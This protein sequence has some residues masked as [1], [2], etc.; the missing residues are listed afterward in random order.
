MIK[1]RVRDEQSAKELL[2]VLV[3]D[4]VNPSDIVV[5]SSSLDKT[6]KL[7]Y[8]TYSKDSIWTEFKDGYINVRYANHF[9][10][11]CPYYAIIGIMDGCAFSEK[12]IVICISE[13]IS[14]EDL[15]LFNSTY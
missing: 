9:I 6:K 13:G 11:A 15:R 14:D 8:S 4:L 10:W 1:F 7:L 5:V 3:W 12:T 2:H